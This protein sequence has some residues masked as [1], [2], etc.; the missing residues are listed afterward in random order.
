MWK[1]LKSTW[2][3][4]TEDEASQLAAALSYYAVVSIAPLLVLLVVIAGFFL[5]REAAQGQLLDQVR[6]TMGA[7][8]TQFLEMVLRNADQPTLASAVGILSFVTLVWGSTNLFAQLQNSLNK[9][10]NVK[11]KPGGGI[12]ATLR[13]RLLAFVMVLGVVVLLIASFVLNAV[14]SAA[15]DWG[16]NILPGADWIWQVVNFMISLGILTLII[17]LIFKVVPH[18]RMAWRDVWLG[19]AGT[20]LLFTFGNFLLGLYLAN[21]GSAYGAAGSVV[22]FLLWVSYS[23]QILFLGAEFTQVYARRHGGVEVE[24]GAV[25]TRDPVLVGEQH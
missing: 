19:A 15:S 12:W 17:A 4:W 11:K 18:V 22:V 23:A 25:R 10:W 5:G 13:S 24:E 16:Q 9:I 8:G 20:A 1:L 3:E 21:V 14:L 2:K 7:E 6:G